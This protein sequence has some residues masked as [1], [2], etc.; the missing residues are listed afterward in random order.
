MVIGL[1]SSINDSRGNFILF[2]DGNPS[3][4]RSLDMVAYALFSV[5]LIPRV[6]P[7]VSLVYGIVLLCATGS[8]GSLFSVITSLC[9]Y[10]II[11]SVMNGAKEFRIL[12]AL[13]AA[14]SSLIHFILSIIVKSS[15][16]SV[17]PSNSSDL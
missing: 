1:F 16:L 14:L 5:K 11:G 8:D 4:T 7:I 9:M 2:T 6:L 10:W 17:R 15:G 13:I 3:N 12:P